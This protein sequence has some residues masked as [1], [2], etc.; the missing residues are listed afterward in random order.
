[1]NLQQYCKTAA[2]NSERRGSLL[3][4]AR[5]IGAIGGSVYKA[6][7]QVAP[8]R[9][10][11]QRPRARRLAPSR[12]GSIGSGLQ[13]DSG[14]ASRLLLRRDRADADPAFPRSALAGAVSIALGSASRRRDFGR[15]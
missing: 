7:K 4:F 11:R 5:A 15:R 12:K 1:V 6:T 10:C 2:I 13:V 3:S 8:R 9:G 14:M